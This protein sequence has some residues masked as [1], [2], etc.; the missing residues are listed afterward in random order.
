MLPS[1]I[2]TRPVTAHTKHIAD[3]VGSLQHPVPMLP[4]ESQRIGGRL[5]GQVES[6]SRT[7]S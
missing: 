1:Q 3:R 4:G 6:K 2:P 5:L 7:K